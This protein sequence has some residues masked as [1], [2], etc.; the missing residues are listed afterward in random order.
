LFGVNPPESLPAAIRRAILRDVR[1]RG[2]RLT[3]HA[4][5]HAPLEF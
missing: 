4:R 3:K 1:A 2:F 5:S